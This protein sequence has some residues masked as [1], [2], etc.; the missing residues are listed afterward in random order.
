[1]YEIDQPEVI[2]FKNTT[3]A[4][5]GAAPTAGLRTLGVDLRQDWLKALRELGFHCSQPTAWG[6]EGLLIGF[7][8]G[9]AQDRLVGDITA[10][11]APG[12][13]FAA[14]HL[15]TQTES[16][17]PHMRALAQRW[18]EH[19]LDVDLGELT[20]TGEHNDVQAYLQARGWDVMGMSLDDLFQAGG[21]A[22]PPLAGVA[23]APVT[24]Q[25]VTATRR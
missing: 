13:R 5:L 10:L 21:I 23:G 3:L 20:Y 24:I 9:E 2:E 6:A 4:Q 7:L 19:G 15:P 12:S 17:A 22:A 25:Y 8:P 11:S 16:M 18:K 14:D 1:V